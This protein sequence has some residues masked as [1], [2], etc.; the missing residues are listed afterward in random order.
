M[1]V[2]FADTSTDAEQVLLALLR[3]APP[4]RKLEMV[5]ELNQTVRMLAEMGLKQR[6]PQA[7]SAQL[8]RRLADLVLGPDLAAHAYG[9]LQQQG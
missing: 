4:W 2:L 9:P 8:D 1:S 6:Y 5:A 3:K 7:G